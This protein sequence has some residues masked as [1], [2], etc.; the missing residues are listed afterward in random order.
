[1]TI[2]AFFEQEAN[3]F[4]RK[5]TISLKKATIFTIRGNAFMKFMRT[6]K[7]FARSRRWWPAL[8]TVILVAWALFV[9]WLADPAALSPGLM[10]VLVLV[11]GLLVVMFT[12][13]HV[14][15][16]AFRKS[17]TLIVGSAAVVAI[18][19]FALLTFVSNE[20]IKESTIEHNEKLGKQLLFEM[21]KGVE[22][23]FDEML[24]D[25][26]VIAED[27]KQ[28]EATGRSIEERLRIY[29]ELTA[30][31]SYATYRINREGIISAMYP[32]D[33]TSLG[34]D[35]SEQAH[36]Q[37][38]ALTH[39]PVI[40]NAFLAVE[41]FTGITLHVPVMK[42]SVYDGTVAYLIDLDVFAE[43]FIKDY[44]V[45]FDSV[46]LSDNVN[47]I[48][49]PP[50]F[51]ELLQ[52]IDS[53]FKTKTSSDFI[54]LTY[55]FSVGDNE[56]CLTSLQNRQVVLA[57]VKR[58]IV[59]QWLIFA[60]L[61]VFLS[62]GG[63][64]L[65]ASLTKELKAE[66]HTQ[67]AALKNS[68]EHLSTTLHSIGDGVIACDRL[69][70]VET[71]NRAAETLT[72]WTTSEAAGHPV[73][74]V[75]PIVHLQT[76]RALNPVQRALREGV[77]VDLANHVALVALDGTERLIAVNCAPIKDASGSVNGAVLVFRD[78]T[79]QY[80]QREELRESE[81]KF[82]AYMEK[83]PL[84]IF[85]TNMEGHYV[86]VNQ[87]ACQMSGYT[88]EELL[89]LSI[90]DFIA[91]EFLEKGMKLFERL[92]K[93][94]YLEAEIM[95]RKKNREIF[96]INLTAVCAADNIVI[97]FCQDITRRK[98][99]EEELK[100]KNI[101]LNTQQEVS[102]D[103]ILVV[104]ERVEIVSFN[105][106]FADI[107]EIPGDIMAS[108]SGQKAL[109]YVLP[110]LVDP[111]E[112]VN[113]INYLNNNKQEIGNEEIALKDGRI[114]ELY[115][116]SMFGDNDRYYGRVYYYRDIT[117]RKVAEE[118]VRY[119]SFHDGLTGLYNR[120]YLEKEMERLNTKRQLPLGMIMADLNGLKLV[121]DTFGHE[122][123]DEL[124]KQ[125]AEI[126]RNSCRKEDIIS[127]W[128]GDEFVVFLP[129]TTE[130][131]L[132]AI[133][134]RIDEKCKETHV[135][136]IPLSLALGTAIK[137]SANMDMAEIL[138]EAE[139]NMYKHKLAESQRVKNTVL[140][141]ML[142][143]LEAKSFET[144]AHY[145]GMQN[146]AESI[147]KG[148]GLSK[149]ELDKLEMLIPL[150]DIG[151][152]NISEEILTRKGPLTAEEWEIIKKH[153]ETGYRIVRATE[154]FAQV[155]ED[156]LSHHERWDG[157]GY[158]QGLMG[159]E[160]PL[161]A[162]ITAIADAYEVMISG[163]PYKKAMSREEVIT[164]LKR[165]SGTQFDAELTKVF[166]SVLKKEVQTKG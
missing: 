94:G 69:G 135:K 61:T 121:N 134:Q 40:S 159:K 56:W 48:I 132:K 157:S 106:R 66:I 20:H 91:P 127:R 32:I 14:S 130:E 129:Q 109:D 41:G 71:L 16:A 12:S 15:D 28:A 136:D 42:N 92:L 54:V 147:G 141:I 18:L 6:M 27:I 26:A 105:Q 11:I 1:L 45:F 164:E 143:N 58:Q 72:S 98:Q 49:Y 70:R 107:W 166:L 165:C 67:T 108:Q 10:F 96:W 82:R 111:E 137:H 101:I 149:P 99:T 5:T 112:F 97:S 31:L 37:Q 29:H 43:R 139:E 86:E 89:N 90:P 23:K 163:R 81:A 160:I 124:L 154:E 150:H 36:M 19:S 142:K 140:K 62:F 123:G 55:Y 17:R 162:R 57:G 84:G 8:L 35:I 87:A 102:L 68:E 118:K 25:L 4:R 122:A 44:V 103:G 2:I 3:L 80:R 38:I 33:E 34:A 73:E 60:G 117:E 79:E 125:A 47:N 13:W 119:Q 76:R 148:I 59:T 53:I 24:N 83:S 152:I 93:E 133:W 46:Y 138:K 161:L 22:T 77:S 7:E 145:S 128:G 156:I 64:L 115:S 75:F 116:S 131:D 63:F 74:E 120:V 126:L 9:W 52:P 113:L 95:V 21:G 65:N 104:N 158:P 146:A 50:Q 39:E 85:V 100:F 51:N 88:E 144:E 110:K 153:P 78:I 151:E 155:A 30:P 114:L